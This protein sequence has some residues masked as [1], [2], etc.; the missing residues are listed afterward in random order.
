MTM[1]VVS[2][3]TAAAGWTHLVGVYDAEARQ[4]RLYVN[5]VAQTPLA[6]VTS[7]ASANNLH[8][9]QALDGPRWVGGIDDVRLYQ[10]PLTLN[11]INLIPSRT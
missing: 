10:T 3:N 5:N 2:G 9:G 8:L 6:G 1:Q 4:I 7:W 11:E